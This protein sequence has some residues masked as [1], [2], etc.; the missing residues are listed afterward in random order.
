MLY[1]K[2]LDQI[3]YMATGTFKYKNE[4]VE[5]YSSIDKL[6]TGNYFGVDKNKP[7]EFEII[8]FDYTYWNNTIYV[9]YPDTDFYI[10]MYGSSLSSHGSI[11]ER[12]LRNIIKEKTQPFVYE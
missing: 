1:K 12:I 11:T 4:N 2:T 8:V 6:K 3:A 7:A 5:V 10:E 9:R